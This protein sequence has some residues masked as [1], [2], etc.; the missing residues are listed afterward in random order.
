MRFVISE[1]I[2]TQAPV[3]RGNYRAHIYSQDGESEVVQ[4]FSQHELVAEIAR[5]TALGQST[6]YYARAL[7]CLQLLN[8]PAKPLSNPAQPTGSQPSHS[9]HAHA[10]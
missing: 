2:R 10:P 8:G 5:L 3:D 9:A 7:Q 4:S 6:A 1:S